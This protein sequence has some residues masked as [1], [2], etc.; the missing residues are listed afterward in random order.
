MFVVNVTR[1]VPCLDEANSNV[2]FWTEADGRADK[3]GQYRMVT[4]MHVDSDRVGREVLFRLGGWTIALIAAEPVREAL[5]GIDG[6]VFEPIASEPR[7]AG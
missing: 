6:A 2:M 4:D 1:S 5:A 3:L 7:G